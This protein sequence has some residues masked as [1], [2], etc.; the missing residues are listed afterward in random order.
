MKKPIR[1]RI[2]HV[3]TAAAIVLSASFAHSATIPVT[4][5]AVH[6]G[7]ST[8]GGTPSD[9]TFTPGDNATLM[10]PFDEVA[11]A[12]DGDSVEVSTTLTLTNRTGTGVNALNTQ[13]RFGLFNG[14]AGAIAAAD[15]PNVG[16]IIEYTNAAAG[17]LIREQASLTQ[18][19]PFT[20]PTNIGNGSP[21]SGGDSLQGANP[22]PITF[23][24]KLTRNGGKLDLAGSISGVDSV[25]GNPYLA[26]Y[27]VNGF[28]SATFPADG[29]FEFNRIGLF[30]GDNVNAAV[31]SLANTTVTAVPE[32]GS[33]ALMVGLAVGGTLVRRCAWNA[34]RR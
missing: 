3:C 5:W 31:A 8:V 27:A 14:P 7:S 19:N 30:L 17:G 2:C 18:T 20:S 26:T 13:L 24:L 11:L 10:A 12:A 32:P 15:V 6:N 25:S 33:L 34:R 28:S 22:G 1:T 21:D 23:L 16:L 9:P 4:G 29:T